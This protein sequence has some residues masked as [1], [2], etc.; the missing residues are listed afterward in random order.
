MDGETETQTNEADCV[1]GSALRFSGVRCQSAERFQSQL[2]E[3]RENRTTFHSTQFNR[4][5]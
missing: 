2:S 1:G 4:G 5:E 3:T